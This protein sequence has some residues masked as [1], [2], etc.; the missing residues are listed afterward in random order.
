[1]RFRLQR[2]RAMPARL[3]SGVLYVSEEFETA[4][5]LCACGCGSKVRTPLGAAEWSFTDDP[6]GPSLHPSVGNWQRPCKA[7]YWIEN[8]RVHWSPQWSA[9]QIAEGRAIEQQ[10]RK[11]YYAQRYPSRWWERVWAWL[12]SLRYPQP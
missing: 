4:A 2:V 11:R 12:K 3:E 9:E 1:M 5:H 10:R 8:G 6:E 7:H